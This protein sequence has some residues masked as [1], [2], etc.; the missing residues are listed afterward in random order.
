MRRRRTSSAILGLASACIAVALAGCTTPPPEPTFESTGRPVPSESVG[1]ADAPVP[2]L[3][4]DLSASENLP[5]FDYVNLAVVAA[6]PAAGGRAFI[7]ALTQAGFDK[8]KMEVTS[9]VTTRDEPA[10]SIQ[11]SVQFQGECLVGQFGPASGGYHGAVRP[12]LG[13]GRC[14][15]GATVPIDW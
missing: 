6:N 14:L 12:L 7:D 8:S 2:T 4:P 15:V 10:D 11:F 5:V 13:T 3:M 1:P 9:D